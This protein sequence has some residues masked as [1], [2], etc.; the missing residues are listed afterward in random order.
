MPLEVDNWN[1]DDTLNAAVAGTDVSEGSL[2]SNLN[3]AVRKVMAAIASFRAVAY[4]KDK[5]VTIAASGGALPAT[6]AEGDWFLEY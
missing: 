1:T 6:P 3:N 4:C 5:N 2:A